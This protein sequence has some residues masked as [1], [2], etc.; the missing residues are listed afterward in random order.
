[1]FLQELLSKLQN[2]TPMDEGPTPPGKR[3][4]NLRIKVC[5]LDGNLTLPTPVHCQLGFDNSTVQRTP[6]VNNSKRLC[7]NSVLYCKHNNVEKSEELKITLCYY[8]NKKLCELSAGTFNL[9]TLTNMTFQTYYSPYLSI[10]NQV[11]VFPQIPHFDRVYYGVLLNYRGGTH[12]YSRIYGITFADK[13]K[14]AIPEPWL[15]LLKTLEVWRKSN[16][17]VHVL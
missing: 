4:K 13:K 2:S 3:T 6:D 8:K 12:K 11:R 5:S 15:V 14:R 7:W 16:F 9:K 1:M 10:K 17:T